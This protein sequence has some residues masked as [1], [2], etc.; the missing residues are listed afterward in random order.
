MGEK[1]QLRGTAAIGP[2]T[3]TDTGPMTS[4]NPRPITRCAT[5]ATRSAAA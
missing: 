2:A 4:P 5:V 1:M 3:I